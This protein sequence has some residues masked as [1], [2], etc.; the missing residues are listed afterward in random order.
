MFYANASK[1][2]SAFR[3]VRLTS[4]VYSVFGGGRGFG[5]KTGAMLGVE[6]PL[7]RR[8]SLLAD[9]YSGNNRL[10]YAQRV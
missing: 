5:T 4:G 3:G 9:W 1:K 10:G 8:I 2:V 6:Q 7:T